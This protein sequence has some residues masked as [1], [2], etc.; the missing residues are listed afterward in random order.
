MMS[1]E[2]RTPMNA[3]IGLTNLLLQEKPRVDQLESMKLLKFSGENLLTIINDILDFSKIEAG[4]ISLEKIDLDLEMLI[5]NT[6]QMLEQRARDKGIDLF[7]KYDETVPRVIKGDQVRLAQIITNLL[8]N[9]IKFTERGY[10]ELSVVHGGIVDGKHK[11]TFKVKDTGI[12]IEA[13]KLNVIFESFS[14]ARADTTRKFG[15]T[16]LGLS[17]TKRMLGLMGTSIEVDS[18]SG[19]GSTFFFTLLCEEGSEDAIIRNDVTDLSDDFQLNAKVLLVEDNRV[20]QIVATNF[21]KKWGIEVAI[22]NHGKEALE[23]IQKNKSYQLVLMDLQ[24][25]EMDGYEASKRIRAL[26]DAY[27]KKIPIIALTASAMIDIKD[28]VIG[29]GMTDFLSKPFHPEELQSM[30][31][32]YVIQNGNNHGRVN[33]LQASTRFQANLDLYTQGDPEFKRELAG[34]LIKGIEELRSSLE[35]T[36]AQNESVIF[37]KAAHKVKTTVSMLGDEEFSNLVEKINRFFSDPNQK[38][39]T[40]ELQNQFDR[41]HELCEVIIQGLREEITSL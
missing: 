35:Q 9:A 14:Q 28:K 16:G 26:D 4:K 3:I 21:L 20:N 11:I 18:K 10:V 7:L 41:F 39:V 12:G 5:R 24:M 15:G 25:P 17:I 33:P 38:R 2:I 31:A 34:L 8:G 13:D 30:I 22:A 37:N 1:H 6:K 29:I 40:P 36:L 27:F 32:R 19:Y 23:M